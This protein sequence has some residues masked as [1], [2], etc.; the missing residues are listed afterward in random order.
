V[1]R[2]LAGLRDGL[3]GS[4]AQQHCVTFTLLR[5]SEDRLG[6]GHSDWIVPVYPQLAYSTSKA[7]TRALI[8]SGPKEAFSKRRWIGIAHLGGGS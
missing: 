8:S 1:G 7:S 3:D 2:G 6:Q 4:L 5:E